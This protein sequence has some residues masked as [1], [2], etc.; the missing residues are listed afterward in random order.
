MVNNLD[1]VFSQTH[2]AKGIEEIFPNFH[3]MGDVEPVLLRIEGRCNWVT[4][5]FVCGI[6]SGS[7]EESTDGSSPTHSGWDHSKLALP[8]EF[9]GI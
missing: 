3:P 1:T 9:S 5:F 8:S 2:L 7:R 4:G 6:L